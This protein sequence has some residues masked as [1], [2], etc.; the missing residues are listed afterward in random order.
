MNRMSHRAIIEDGRRVNGL[1][2]GGNIYEYENYIE[3][4]QCL[5]KSKGQTSSAMLFNE[6]LGQLKKKY[7]K[8]KYINAE[9]I[10][11]SCGIYGVTGEIHMLSM[12][13]D[14]GTL[15]DVLFAYC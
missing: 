5:E 2:F 9:Q 8:L 15:L 14:D 1:Y 13:S 12:Y 11:Y 3:K 10:G 4:I 7:P 6:K